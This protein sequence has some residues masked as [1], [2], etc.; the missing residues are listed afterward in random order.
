MSSPRFLISNVRSPVGRG[1][2]Q[3]LW[4]DL[5][6]VLKRNHQV[7]APYCVPN[8]AICSEIGRFLGLPIPPGALTVRREDPSQSYYA[9]LNFNLEGELI[10]PLLPRLAVSTWPQ[11][12]AGTLLFDILIANGDRHAQNLAI[13]RSMNPYQLILFDHSHA[14]FGSQLGE[15]SRRFSRLR[16]HL[17]VAEG[18]DPSGN[19]HC[20]LD[21][22]HSDHHFRFWINRISLLPNYWIEEVCESMVG[23]G[24]TEDE[25][26]MGSD[27]LKDRRD[28]LVA[29][30][31][32]NQDDFAISNW[33]II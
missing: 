32:E 8:E 20:L 31:G 10:P 11:V 7:N 1:I 9:S 24:I 18:T 15:V 23:F 33:S 19:R 13:N 25:A 2:T 5:S 14:L 17:G 3:P 16:S 4:A 29:I 28:H 12:C 26:H 6:V 21:H 30:L 27:F 22:L